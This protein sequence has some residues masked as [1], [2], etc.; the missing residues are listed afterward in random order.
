MHPNP[1]A[2]RQTNT[3]AV[4]S[5]ICGILGL[6]TCITAPVA[7]VMGHMARKQIAQSQGREEGEGLAIAG[8]ALG[9][10]VTILYGLVFLFYLVF[11]VGYVA[12]LAVLIGS[13][14]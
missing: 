2:P 13:G 11:F 7:I 9:Y 5:L 1:Y 14:N 6:G 12:L 10:F 4:I 3:T 8:L